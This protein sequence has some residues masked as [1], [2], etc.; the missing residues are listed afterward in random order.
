[1]SW[2]VTQARAREVAGEIIKAQL[3][4]TPAA[5][6]DR[7]QQFHLQ[8]RTLALLED[9]R[10]AHRSWAPDL[11]ARK[12]RVP[13]VV[14]LPRAD[15]ANG[16]LKVLG[17]ISDVRSRRSEQDPLLVLA[18]IAHADVAT[19]LEAGG[20]GRAGAAQAAVGP[21]RELGQ[22][23]ESPSGTQPWRGVGLDAARAADPGRAQLGLHHRAHPGAGAPDGLA[24]VVALGGPGGPR[25]GCRG[26]AAAQ[27]ATDRT[28]LRRAAVGVQR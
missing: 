22:Q 17:A 14:F 5:E 1:M 15:T 20:P 25:A 3:D 6:R 26:R 2:Y 13:P 23:S 11:R 19:W 16:G 21:V 4:T 9:L 28:V 12:R 10:V 27:P 24:S 7:A 8:L 18:G